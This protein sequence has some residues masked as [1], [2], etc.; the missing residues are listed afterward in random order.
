MPTTHLK[1]M[2]QDI[3]DATLQLETMVQML[4]S[5]ALYL[6]SQKI[7][8]LM[9]DILLIENQIE[10]LVLSIQDLKKTTMRITESGQQKVLP[11]TT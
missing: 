3:N 6:R 8:H 9:M 5:H 1:D 10:S 11:L 2:Q 4:R 7:E